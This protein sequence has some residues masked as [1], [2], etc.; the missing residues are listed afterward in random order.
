MGFAHYSTAGKSGQQAGTVFLAATYRYGVFTIRGVQRN[1]RLLVPQL[2][3]SA[4]LHF[5][6]ASVRRLAER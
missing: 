6:V 5:Q 3:D 2:G 1:A 4:T